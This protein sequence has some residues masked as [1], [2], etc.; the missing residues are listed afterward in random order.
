MNT[1]HDLAAAIGVAPSLPGAR[2]V[3]RPQA[4]ES[5]LRS[6]IDHAIAE[7]Q[8]CPALTDCREWFDGLKPSQRPEGVT[9]AK[10]HTRKPPR[11]R[12]KTR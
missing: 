5:D 6:D 12:K 2:C 3:G 9:A 10:I 11:V 7:C 8:R 4:W 1:W